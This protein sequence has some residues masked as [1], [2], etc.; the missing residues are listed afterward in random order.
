[1]NY[2]SAL[3]VFGILSGTA[4]LAA[5]PPGTPISFLACPVARDTGPDT[6]VCFFAEYKG[7]RYVLANP[8][9]FGSPQ[10]K[11]Q[12]L[13]EARVK[14]GTRCGATVIEGRVSVMPEVDTAC[15]TIVPFDGVIKG[16]VGGVFLSGTPQQRAFAEDLARRAAV[17]PRLTVVP[18]IEN[19]APPPLPAPPFTT[20][21][22]V[23]A[24][25]FDSDRGPGPDMV[26]LKNLVDYV[27]VA[28]AKRVDIL[29]NRAT[30]RLSD[31]SEMVEKPNLAEARARKIAGI[32][33]A[34]GVDEKLVHVRWESDAIAGKGD[35][36]WRNRK[37]EVTVTP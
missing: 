2:R 29:G 19:P 22:L 27:R 37:V 10:L 6:D 8:P 11:H 17:D 1:M 28:K 12:V 24:Y 7:A 14:E 9:D 34:L 15:D 4:V 21:T 13:V 23:I 30:S 36:D 31:G 5:E 26:K 18:A 25:P 35:E 16:E 3:L 33:T 20:Q 32:M